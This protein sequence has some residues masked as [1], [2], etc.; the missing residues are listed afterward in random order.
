MPNDTEPIDPGSFP[1]VTS[2]FSSDVTEGKEPLTV[3]FEDRST[4]SEGIKILEWEWN[5]G[6]G[7]TSNEQNPA[8][9]Y[10]NKG[11]FTVSLKSGDGTYFGNASKSNYIT[12]TVGTLDTSNPIKTWDDV[13]DGKY[14]HHTIYK[15]TNELG[16]EYY[17]QVDE[18]YT[19]PVPEEPPVVQNPLD[20][21]S[22]TTDQIVTDIADLKGQVT[23]IQEALSITTVQTGP[24]MGILYVSAELTA[25]KTTISD[26]KK[27]I[28]EIQTT[29]ADIKSDTVDIKA[30]TADIKPG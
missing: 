25:I 16:G 7:E 21:L 12:V 10:S 20:N 29:T 18:E 27:T 14:Y 2:D 26:L 9:T 5:F 30:S 23:Q 1:S 15:T 3:T 24:Q 22:A 4:A 6:D 17:F 8:H 11:L 19:P 13:V 28:A